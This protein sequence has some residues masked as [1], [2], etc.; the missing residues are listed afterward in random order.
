M[1]VK[2][3]N[4]KQ[5]TFDEWYRNSIESTMQANHGVFKG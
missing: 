1:S 3:D 4:Q 2:Y 5:T